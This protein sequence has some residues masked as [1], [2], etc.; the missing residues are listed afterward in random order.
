MLSLFKVKLPK[1]TIKYGKLLDPI[2]VFY[3]KNKQDLKKQGWNDWV[4]PAQEKIKQRIYDYR[5]EWGKSEEKILRGMCNILEM[6]FKR[7]IIDVYIVSG[8]SR[9]LS[10]PIVIKSGFKPNEFVDSLTHE[11]IHKLFEDNIKKF[12]IMILKEMFPNE[13]DTTRNHVITHSV[14][15]YIY[16]DVLKDKSRLERNLEVSRKHRTNDYARAWEI[17]EERGYV[18]LIKLLKTK[19]K[20][21][22]SVY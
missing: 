11:L 6:K 8:S 19:I 21:G 12:P 5:Q 2:F 18:E 17:V 4:P 1:I 3:C 22:L 16:L 14:L 7:N 13:T 10:D 15:K 9:Q 20:R